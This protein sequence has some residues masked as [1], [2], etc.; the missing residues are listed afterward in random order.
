[1]YLTYTVFQQVNSGILVEIQHTLLITQHISNL[2]RSKHRSVPIT[3]D[4][5][6]TE[7]AKNDKRIKQVGDQLHEFATNKEN[8][9]WSTKTV[10]LESLWMDN[11]QKKQVHMKIEFKE[12][13]SILSCGVVLE[14]AH[15]TNINVSIRLFRRGTAPEG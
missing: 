9:C 15:M 11:G 7:T 4:D 1:M 6:A 3:I 5:T 8:G 14:A 2:T 12:D 10:N 13:V